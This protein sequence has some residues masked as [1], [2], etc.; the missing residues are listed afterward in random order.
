MWWESR[1]AIAGAALA[2]TIPLWF[3]TLPPL[4]D[5]LGHMGRY[6][7]QISLANSPAL[8]AN[9]DYH[10]QLIGNLGADLLMEPLGRA[11]GVERGAVVLGGLLVVVMITG[12]AR[13]AR[14]AH[15]A[16]PATAWAAFPFACAYPW[17]YGLVNYWLGVGLA[18]HAAASGWEERPASRQMLFLGIASLLLWVVHIYGWAVF[19]ILI[20]VRAVADR[21]LK[22]WPRAALGLWPLGLPAAVMLALSSG[23]AGAAAET[24]GWFE[25]GYKLLALSWTLRDQHEWFDLACLMAALFLIYAGF[26]SKAF[27]TDRALALGALGLLAALVVLPYQFLGSAYADARLWPVVFIVA[28][29]AI[30]PV[31]PDGRLAA[32]LALGAA[33]VFAVRIAATTVGFQAYDAAYAQHLKALDAMP[34]GSR[35]AVF[36]EFP[37]SVDWRRPRIEHLDGI[38]IVRRD[39][40][41]NAQ[42]DVPGAQLLVPLAARGTR[43]NS[44]PSQLVM[45]EG[46]LRP[47][48]A[49]RIAKFPRDR[50]DMVW[51]VGYRPETLPRYAGLTPVFADDRTILYR[52]EK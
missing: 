7:V 17:Q 11:F 27:A 10:W 6:H 24:L 5:L 3:V 20:A 32:G 4:I 49:R 45:G 9:W 1:V 22:D 44:D 12:M 36:V 15:G 2:A 14:A 46:D 37:L 19:A 8:Q 48:L 30:R 29:L 51:V 31:Q 47:A 43:F 50:F 52:I 13:L 40:F 35:I 33:A 34:R 38:A 16:V 28:L 26:R 42:W 18:L 25:I 39:V 41:T 23:Q 21:S